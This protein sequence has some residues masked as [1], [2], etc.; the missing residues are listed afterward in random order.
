MPRPYFEMLEGLGTVGRK[1]LE[2]VGTGVS[3]GKSDAGDAS[4]RL[5]VDP[6]DVA[7]AGGQAGSYLNANAL[8]HLEE[9]PGDDS[10][11]AR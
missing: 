6:D 2:L 3:E 8:V 7:G 1:G 4:I 11:P 10:Y 5:L 9:I